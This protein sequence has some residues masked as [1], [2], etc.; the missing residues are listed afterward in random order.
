MALH[1][2]AANT[3]TVSF[4]KAS[5]CVADVSAVPYRG[6]NPFDVAQV[7]STSGHHLQVGRYFVTRSAA[8][9]SDR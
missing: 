6:Q 9:L 4:D 2:S 8:A 1:A 7:V 5:G 3:V